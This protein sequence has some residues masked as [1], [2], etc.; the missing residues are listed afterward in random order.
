M[1]PLHLD[2]GTVILRWWAGVPLMAR[3]LVKA[4]I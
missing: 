2:D 4:A 3:R 1:A